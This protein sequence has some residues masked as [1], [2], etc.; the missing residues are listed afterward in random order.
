MVSEISK[1][2]SRHTIKSVNYAECRTAIHNPFVIFRMI[3]NKIESIK[4]QNFFNLV[5]FYIRANINIV[6]Q[7]LV[8]SV[9]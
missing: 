4:L 1:S 9:F 6:R 2:K 7:F 8:K 3:I 5:L